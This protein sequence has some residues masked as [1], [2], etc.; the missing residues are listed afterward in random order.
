MIASLTG[1]IEHLG[2]TELVLNVNG[3]GYQ[4]IIPL[5]TFEQLEHSVG[6]ATVLTHMHV[7]EDAIQLYGFATGA[8]RDMFRLLISITGIGRKLAETMLSGIG[9]PEVRQEIEGADHTALVSVPG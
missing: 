4:V 5:S 9:V 6:P 7:R 2:P 1:T 3:V 8:E